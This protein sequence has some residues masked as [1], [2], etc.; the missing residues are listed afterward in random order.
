MKEIRKQPG[1]AGFLRDRGP[2]HG[3][4]KN[5]WTIAE[6]AWGPRAGS[7]NFV[8]HVRVRAER[9]IPPW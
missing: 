9:D 1:F 6:F 7:P 8:R 4:R 2:G 5:G 3:E